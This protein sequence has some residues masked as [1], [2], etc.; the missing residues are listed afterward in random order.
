M[1]A[2]D[3]ISNTSPLQ[4]LHQ[5]GELELLP[6]LFRRVVVPGAVES[7]LAA[8]RALGYALPDIGALS[9]VD[10]RRDIR[11]PCNILAHG[12]LGAGE[13]EVL[14]LA[15]TIPGSM[16]FLDD[17]DARRAALALDIPVSGTLGILLFAKQ[18]GLIG[19]VRPRLDLLDAARFRMAPRLRASVLDRAGEGL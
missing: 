1:K 10:L 19:L 4:Y 13:R 7:E 9:W 2:A 6:K 17:G 15:T 16:V 14:W 12:D 18:K 8:G 3:Y 11:A 5:I